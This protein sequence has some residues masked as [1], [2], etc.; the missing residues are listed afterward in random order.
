MLKSNFSRSYYLQILN[1]N[2]AIGIA[3][4]FTI[5]NNLPVNTERYKE[6][7]REKTHCKG[8]QGLATCTGNSLS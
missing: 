3:R 1:N 5:N 7:E 4:F 8:F 6:V 2:C